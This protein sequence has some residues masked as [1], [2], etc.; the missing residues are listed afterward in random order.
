MYTTQN[1]R[2]REIVYRKE[3]EIATDNRCIQHRT[4]DRERQFIERRGK[5]LQTDVYNIEQL[6][7]R[8]IVYREEGEEEVATDRQ[9][10][11][12]QNNRQIERKFIE[13]RGR[14]LQIDVYNIEQQIEREIVRQRGGGDSY[15]QIDVYNIEQQIE[16]DNQIERRR[17]QLQIDRCM[18]HRTIDRER[19]LDREEEEEVATD[20]QMYT[21]Q[22]NRQREIARQKGGG[23]RYK[24]MYTTQNNR[25]RGG[26]GS[27]RQIDVCNMKQQ[28]EREIVRQRGGGRDSY[29]QI[30]VYNIEQW[31]ER[32]IVRQR[33]GGGGS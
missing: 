19:Q 31:I 14:Q 8:E 27:Y 3:E 32:E 4:I 20:R 22:N 12:T 24:E 13:R 7:D 11:T 1:N 15:R 30:D 21:T 28:I 5:Q 33:G 23:G 26:G 2:Q 9:M 25:Q 17:K 18:Q 29:R 6:I 16:R 10:Y